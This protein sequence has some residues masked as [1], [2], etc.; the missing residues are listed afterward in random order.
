MDTLEKE[1]EIWDG[2]KTDIIKAIYLKYEQSPDFS[3]VLIQV[4]EQQKPLQM[5]ASW[6]LK[7]HLENG[8][9]FTLA[10][11]ERFC[12]LSKHLETWEAQLHFLQILPKIDLNSQHLELLLPF[13][14]QML[15][16]SNKFVKAWAYNALAI[17]TRLVP[18]LWPEMKTRFDFALEEESPSVKAR[19]RKALKENK[20]SL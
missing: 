13:I 8:Q 5:A 20:L 12:K 10:E 9:T 6:L 7:H 19:I 15:S 3:S 18:E 14:D 16:S 4:C 1:L 2:K 17:S 11:T